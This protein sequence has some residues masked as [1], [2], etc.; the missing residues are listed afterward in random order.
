MSRIRHQILLLE[1]GAKAWDII[2]AIDEVGVDDFLSSMISDAR[3]MQVQS[4]TDRTLIQPQIGD[5]AVTRGPFTLC[6]N[7][8]YGYASLTRR[9]TVKSAPVGRGNTHRER[10]RH[11]HPGHR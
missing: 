11:E 4:E 6:W 7:T 5:E 1:D 8:K 3:K 2:R 9:M 10:F